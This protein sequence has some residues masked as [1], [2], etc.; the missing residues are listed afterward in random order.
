MPTKL[1]PSSPLSTVAEG[2]EATMRLITAPPAETGTGRF[3]NGRAEARA[4]DQAYDPEARRRLRAL[5]A[6]LT[7]L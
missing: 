6:D 3:F 1:S 7:G 2:V 4:N 5:S